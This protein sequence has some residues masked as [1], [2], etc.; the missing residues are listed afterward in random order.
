MITWAFCILI[1]DA[2]LFVTIFKL[3]TADSKTAAI[4]LSAGIAI[5]AAGILI[6]TWAK[7]REGRFEKLSNE[8]SAVRSENKELFERIATIRERQ[9]IERTDEDLV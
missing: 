5:C 4:I 2:L 3:G 9:I 7:I 6:R 8:L 1:L